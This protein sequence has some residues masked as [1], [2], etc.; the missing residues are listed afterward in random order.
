MRPSGN[1]LRKTLNTLAN[2]AR[3]VIRSWNLAKQKHSGGNSL[4]RGEP[5]G[6]GRAETL[7]GAAKQE[8]ATHEKA[9]GGNEQ[10]RFGRGHE[11]ANPCGNLVMPP[12][13]RRPSVILGTA[14]AVVLLGQGCHS[15]PG[16][17]FLSMSDNGRTVTA[18]VGDTI[19]VVLK[20]VGPSY[21][22]IPVLSSASVIFLGE[23]DQFLSQANPGGGKTQRYT[24]WAVAPGQT[25]IRIPRDQPAP[26]FAV[27]VQVAPT[28]VV[29]G[30]R[31]NATEALAGFLRRLLATSFEGDAFRRET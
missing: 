13:K 30:P 23:A 22:G 25:E 15:Q 7:S 5:R 28:S 24:F 1:A 12:G 2:C 17:M 4:I 29:L 6:T 10:A 11:S 18:Q 27:T 21:F 9:A 31:S 19:V 16:D 26:Q 3:P 20:V 14:A 8:E